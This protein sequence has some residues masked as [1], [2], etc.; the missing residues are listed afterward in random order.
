MVKPPYTLFGR[1]WVLWHL[2]LLL[3]GVGCVLGLLAM[4]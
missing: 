1:Q 3:L 4:L 2:G